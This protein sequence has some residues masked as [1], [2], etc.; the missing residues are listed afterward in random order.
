M[1]DKKIT[2]E[3]E[4]FYY[5][6]I[7]IPMEYGGF[8]D[9]AFYKETKE[10]KTWFGLWTKEEPVELFT[11]SGWIE[12]VEKYPTKQKLINE[13]TIKYQLYKTTTEQQVLRKLEIERGE[14]NK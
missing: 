6:A 3:G 10:V 5:R 2:I 4:E 12:D 13:I 1:T 9:T 8:W 14:L 7:W 11:V